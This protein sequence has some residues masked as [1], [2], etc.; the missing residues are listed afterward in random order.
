[1]TKIK[2]KDPKVKKAIKDIK[3]ALLKFSK[4]AETGT[5]EVGEIQQF[6]KSGDVPEGSS[7]AQIRKYKTLVEEQNKLKDFVANKFREIFDINEEFK[8]AMLRESRLS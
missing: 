4:S 1:M 8:L 3:E 2:Q 6:I 5:F 7:A